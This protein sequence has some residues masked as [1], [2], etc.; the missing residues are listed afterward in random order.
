MVQEY[1]REEKIE[2]SFS[3]NTKTN[4]YFIDSTRSKTKSNVLWFQVR[5]RLEKF[6]SKYIET[7][8][9]N[10]SLVFFLSTQ[11]TSFF[12]TNIVYRQFVSST[13]EPPLCGI[14]QL[15]K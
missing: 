11:A 14:F 1:W 2:P 9:Q 12:A 10:W 8:S 13:R 7:V 15:Q 5:R 3:L 4:I 6:S